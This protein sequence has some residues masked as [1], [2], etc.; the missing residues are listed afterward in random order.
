MAE[1]PSEMA[2]PLGTALGNVSY[3]VRE[4]HAR[5][6]LKMTKKVPRRGA[7]QHYYEVTPLGAPGPRPLRAARVP[8]AQAA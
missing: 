6:L 1:S 3:H 5:A 2:G 4:L 8:E 7:I